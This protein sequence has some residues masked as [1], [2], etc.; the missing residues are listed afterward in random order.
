[1]RLL[2]SLD[3][4]GRVGKGSKKI[5]P[6]L[7]TQKIRIAPDYKKTDKKCSRI[8]E[9]PLQN[10]IGVRYLVVRREGS[11]LGY[12]YLLPGIIK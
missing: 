11:G 10:F 8:A 5:L 1:M 4:R 7:A 6:T 9:F 2:A 12:R 3:H